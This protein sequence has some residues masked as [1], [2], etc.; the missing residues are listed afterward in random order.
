M[1]PHELNFL[2]IV[3]V[4]SA[5]VLTAYTFFAFAAPPGTRKRVLAITGVAALLVLLTGIRMWQ[6]IYAFAP[7]GWIIVKV[8]CWLGVSALSGMAYRKRDR[9]GLLMI[10]GLVLLI[11]AVAMAYA[12][13]F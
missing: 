8:V 6:G 10:I 3:H 7:L 2:H 11:T 1:N 4:A 5:L 9:A 13:P 12:R